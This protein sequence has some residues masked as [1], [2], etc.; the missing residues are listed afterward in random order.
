MIACLKR[1][2][3]QAIVL[4]V[5]H[6]LQGENRTTNPLNRFLRIGYLIGFMGENNRKLRDRHSFV[7]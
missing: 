6:H 2:G 4:R 3:L 1:K 7:N 5:H